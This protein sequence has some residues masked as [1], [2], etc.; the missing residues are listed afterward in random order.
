MEILKFDG[1]NHKKCL[2]FIGDNYN[3]T[4]SYPNVNTKEGNKE[5]KVGD[6]I[7]KDG[8]NYLLLKIENIKLKSKNNGK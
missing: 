6:V 7:V 4:L 5:V 1:N 2:E 3:N 8:E